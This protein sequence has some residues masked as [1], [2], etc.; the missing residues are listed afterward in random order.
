M[1]SLIKELLSWQ[2]TPVYNYGRVQLT[3][4]D[5]TAREH[6]SRILAEN[7][8][9]EI[10]LILDMARHDKKILELIEERA[11]IRWTEG[12]PGDLESAVVSNFT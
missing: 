5:N 9:L 12:L 4:G 11:A 3:G 1:N 7:P 6:Y 2:I 10:Q 8:E